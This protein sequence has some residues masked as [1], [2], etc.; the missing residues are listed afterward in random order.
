MFTPLILTIPIFSA[1][2]S[3]AVVWP[4]MGSVLMWMLIVFVGCALV[5]IG[6]AVRE[7]KRG[8]A[9]N[10]KIADSALAPIAPVHADRQ[11][12]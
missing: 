2:A 7:T 9:A 3:G 4:T 6:G 11:A 10:K 1:V 12:A 8:R 5:L